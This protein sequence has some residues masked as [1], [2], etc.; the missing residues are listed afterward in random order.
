MR[1]MLLV[2]VMML[3]A[4]VPVWC[5][6]PIVTSRS[7]YFTVPNANI[8]GD[9]AIDLSVG[10]FGGGFVSS[11]NDNLFA[12]GLGFD[13]LEVTVNG[14]LDNFSSDQLIGSIKYQID[15]GTI[16]VDGFGKTKAA[17]F[18]CNLGDSTS[19]VP[20]MAFTKSVFNGSD[21]SVAVWNNEG[22]EI[23]GALQLFAGKYAAPTVEYSTESKLALGV[24]LAYKGLY[25]RVVY[26]ENSDEW[27]ANVG[28]VISW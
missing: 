4:A 26:L 14:S 7:D 25:G 19:A 15:P 20:G 22:W 17:I 8:L 5:D 13:S 11:D 28:Q 16:G 10:S 27:Y 23:G 1:T 18:V 2:V 3:C 21:A 12:V 9:R 24:D 6:G